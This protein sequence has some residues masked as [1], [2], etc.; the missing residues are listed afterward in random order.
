MGIGGEMFRTYTNVGADCRDARAMFQLCPQG[1]CRTFVGMASAQMQ[2]TMEILQQASE[3]LVKVNAAIAK[4]KD[5]G[6]QGEKMKV[7]EGIVFT[8][9]C[10][11]ACKI[12][13]RCG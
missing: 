13:W 11:K 7:L 1:P 12:L 4:L 9:E 6:E 10:I 8:L 2:K 5:D 3:M